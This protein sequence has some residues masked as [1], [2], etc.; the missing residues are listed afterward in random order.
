MRRKQYEI[1]WA[2]GHRPCRCSYGS[3]RKKV[4]R[5]V[6]FTLTN[7]RRVFTVRLQGDEISPRCTPRW[8]PFELR[9]IYGL[10]RHVLIW[11]RRRRL[12]TWGPCA[13]PSTCKWFNRD[14]PRWSRIPGRNPWCGCAGFRNY[15]VLLLRWPV[16]D[17]GC[18]QEVLQGVLESLGESCGERPNR[19]IGFTLK[20]K[21]KK[22]VTG[23]R[24]WRSVTL[25][26]RECTV[27]FCVK[28][29]RAMINR[30]VLNCNVS[31]WA[32]RVKR[33]TNWKF[34]SFIFSVLS[35]KP[36]ESVWNCS[37]TFLLLSQVAPF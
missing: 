12:A 18:A 32:E 20:K 7:L 4:I 34:Q 37:T 13:A 22:G 27:L 3:R 33:P 2:T 8:A 19:K 17:H 6:L 14:E 29:A 36:V 16:Y 21:Q 23:R 9:F 10:T 31:E 1:S 5:T 24:G 30:C 11:L 28:H 35:S 15:F 26:F 25:R